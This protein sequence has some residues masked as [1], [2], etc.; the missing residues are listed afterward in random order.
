MPRTSLI[1]YIAP[2]AISVTP[3]ANGSANDLA[4]YVAE[5]TKMKV[6]SPAFPELAPENGSYREWT[7]TG[8]NR[9]LARSDAPY[10]IYARLS[11]TSSN[12]Y[13]VFAPK[14]WR[15]T[16]YSDKYPYVTA[17]GLSTID[18][19]PSEEVAMMIQNNWFIRLGDVSLPSA[20]KRTVTF[21]TGILGT[22]Q[23]NEE[24]ELNPDNMPLRIDIGC[25][26]DDEDAGP[27]P[28]VYWGKQLVLNASLVEG[29]NTVNVGRFDHWEITRN[30]GDVNADLEWNAAAGQR[31]TVIGD[32]ERTF[33]ESGQIVLSHARGVGDDFN[34]A[35]AATFIVTAFGKPEESD[36]SSS[37][38]SSSDSSSSGEQELE[39]LATASITILA[40]TAEKYELVLSSSIAAYNPQ[41]DAYRPSTIAV[42]VRATDQRGEVFM[43]T[44]GQFDNA[45]LAMSYAVVGSDV[46]TPLPVETSPA[47]VA[48]ALIGTADAFAA[49]QS[50]V[51]RLV[52]V[53]PSDSSSSD[54]E[55]TV[56]ELT[57]STI[58][59]VRDGEDSK[60]REWIFLRSQTP[61]TFGGVGSDNPYPA[62]I[63]SGEV[64][65]SDAARAITTDKDQDGWVPEGWY[66]EMQGADSTVKYEY[67]SYRDYG[68]NSDSS[69]S[70][71]GGKHWGE[72]C[73]PVLWRSFVAEGMAGN[74]PIQLFKWF[75]SSETIAAP[76]VTKSDWDTNTSQSLGGW[77]KSAP[78]R[79]ANKDLYMSQNTLHGDG[80]LDASA[81]STPVRISG[82][83]GDPGADAK[84]REWIYIGVSTYSN[85]YSGT[86]PNEISRGR[87]AGTGTWIPVYY[88]DSTDDYVPEGWS[89]TAIAV[90]DT[91][92]KFVFASWRDWDYDNNE[93]EDFHDP[94]LWSNWGVQGIDGDGVQYVY[95]L[96]NHELTDAERTSNIPAKPASQDASGEWLP[97]GWDDNPLAPT[98]SMPFCYCSVIKRISGVWGTFEKL[99]LWSKWSMDGDTAWVA[100]LDNEIDS[101]SCEDSSHPVSDQTVSTNISLYFGTVEKTFSITQVKRKFG[102]GNGSTQTWSASASSGTY[103][104]YPSW[105]GGALTM[106]YAAA[107]VITG[108]DIIEITI[109]ATEDATVERTLMF[110]VNGIVG[111][112]YNLRPTVNQVSVGSGAVTAYLYCGYTK[113]VDGVTTEY[114]P[115]PDT[116]TGLHIDSRYNIYFRR[117]IRAGQTVGGT[118]YNSDTWEDTYYLL[119]YTTGGH[120]TMLTSLD[121][122][123][124]NSVEFYLCTST[125]A[126]R[127]SL[128]NIIDKETVPV[129]SDG[130]DGGSLEMYEITATRTAANFHKDGEGGSYTPTYIDV[131]SGYTKTTGTGVTAYEWPASEGTFVINGNTHYIVWRKYNSAGSIVPTFDGAQV[132]GWDRSYANSDN[133]TDSTNNMGDGLVRLNGG[134]RIKNAC[135]YSAIEFAIAKKYASA[136]TSENDI[137]SRITIPINKVSDG[138]KGDDGNSYQVIADY[139]G[140]DVSM[141]TFSRNYAGTILSTMPSTYTL[142]L[143]ENGTEVSSLP[144]EWSWFLK[145]GSASW[146]FLSS[147]KSVARAQAGVIADFSNGANATATYGVGTDV[148]NILYTKLVTMRFEVQRMLVPAGEWNS[149][150]LYSRTD[151][152]TPLVYYPV[153]GQAQYWYLIT[154]SSQG[155]VPG[156]GSSYWAPC[157]EFDVILT[158]ML[159]AEFA[160][161]GSFIV[162]GDHFLSQYGT[163]V[164]PNSEIPVTAN[165]VNTSYS[166]MSDIVLNGNSVNNGRIVCKVSFTASANARIKMTVTPSSEPNYDYGAIGVLGKE[167]D[168]GNARWL[169]TASASD[170]KAAESVYILTKASGTTSANTTLTVSSAGT[171]FFEVA[172]TKDSSGNNYDDSVS[173]QLQVLSGTVTWNSVTQVTATSGMSYRGGPH[174]GVPYSW[175]DPDDPMAESKPESGYKFRPTKCINA[176]TGEEWSANG[177]IHTDAEGNVI[178]RNALFASAISAN[179]LDTQSVNGRRIHIEGG[180]FNVHDD[181]GNIGLRIGWDDDDN[182][183]PYII[184]SNTD[185]TKSWKVTYDGVKEA[186]ATF[187]QDKFNPIDLN[188][189]GGS[190][191]SIHNNTNS[192]TYY[193]YTAAKN[194]VTGAYSNQNP[195]GGGGTG[196]WQTYRANQNN[197][198]FTTNTVTSVVSAN[199]S[200]YRIP[201]GYYISVEELPSSGSNPVIYSRYLYSADNG[202]LAEVGIVY[203]YLDSSVG[204]W[205]DADGSNPKKNFDPT[206]YITHESL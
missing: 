42:R 108:K 84:E 166:G 149:T 196:M 103:G 146:I 33:A 70:D 74:S 98:E 182:G 54:A 24:W 106:H 168:P 189:S 125:G 37:S 160:R 173:F 27:T 41:A 45:G 176:L 164:S 34:G 12:G 202:I 9:R 129:L 139:N 107:A 23:Y 89:D 128:S 134:I 50:V 99:G 167:E 71:D 110:I 179:T 36:S 91:T 137:I 72:F 6:Y 43:L 186:S 133:P 21:D 94:I 79:V 188:P 67:G 4:V 201:N 2:S 55:P 101:V 20:G 73:A 19:V 16:D 198:V 200:N 75:G 187:S 102:P 115:T 162:Y 76:T 159:F 174:S 26:V 117:R 191:L 46:W 13:L 192:S 77:S 51:V 69:S 65:P 190:A 81:W 63:A 56:T 144:S 171:Y 170:V 165:N 58:A 11:K 172:Y 96:F 116:S 136:I 193:R 100:D 68:R 7:L 124:Y 199:G 206:R 31:Q 83:D 135:N 195:S 184:L 32:V 169:E 185:G 194:L 85:P 140:G 92:N 60:E 152:T 47:A 163:L 157:T 1:H 183:A 205:C 130:E 86:N 28:Y 109:Q 119:T 112:V 17:D 181:N 127:T 62:L 88:K 158:K 175:F 59:F 138:E 141:V 48:E 153:T 64:D 57:T 53:T 180:V 66:D 113:R 203:Y 126:T 177:N 40:E 114:T 22:D 118:T 18:D 111:D 155:N 30:S 156:S 204:M 82:E 61:V 154:D 131:V 52:R 15:H 145:R 10:T 123:T 93:W 148:N 132:L 3:N 80:T 143:M 151:N 120:P 147:N 44:R 161:L 122:A 38:S 49:Q 121:V 25:T 87:Q 142:R 8:R 39:V 5:G 78:N 105:S 95:K 97:T 14:S 35:V 178:L 197:K 29:W 90:D 150:T 104:V